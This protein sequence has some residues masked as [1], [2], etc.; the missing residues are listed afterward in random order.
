MAVSHVALI[1]RELFYHRQGV[2]M[3]GFSV[4]MLKDYVDIF[5]FAV[6]G[7]ASFLALWFV[8]ER[9]IFYSKVD[10]K[11]YDD[12]DALNLDLT[13]NLTILYVI[14][15]NAPYVGLL[16][17]VLGIMVVFYDMGVSGGM[18]AKTIMVDLSLALKA[19][20]LGLAVAIP[21]LIAYNSLL[22]KSDVLSEKFRIMKK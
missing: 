12:I 7:V 18:D 16:G 20:A 17:T 5:V 2:F 22:R 14:F 10:L 6:L 4:G 9:V 19:T 1:L 13:K 15:S 8:I 3:G 11:A 21:T